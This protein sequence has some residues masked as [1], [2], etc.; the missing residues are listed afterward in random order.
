[1][2]EG[3]P[4]YLLIPFVYSTVLC[5][6]SYA[7]LTVQWWQGRRDL[8]LQ[9]PVICLL[10]IVVAS[11]VLV[12]NIAF[13]R[14]YPENPRLGM[15]YPKLPIEYIRIHKRTTVVAV[16]VWVFIAA[17]WGVLGIVPWLLL[18]S[19]SVYLICFFSVK[20]KRKR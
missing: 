11:A 9:I 7:M 3:R 5:V 19:F 14:K 15:L 8:N 20:L 12:T 18:G 10:A 1:M 13:D 16:A 17:T 6:T 4:P 2:D